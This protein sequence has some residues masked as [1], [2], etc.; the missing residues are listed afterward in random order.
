MPAD[1]TAAG[2]WEQK[3]SGERGPASSQ[4][5]TVQ[6]VSPR[7]ADPPEILL[8]GKH[9][10]QAVDLRGGKGSSEGPEQSG[11]LRLEPG[12]PPTGVGRGQV[13]GSRRER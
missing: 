9:W 2:T 7:L 6:H 10:G 8:S 3:E 11:S 4:V 12:P 5:H 1:E 13:V